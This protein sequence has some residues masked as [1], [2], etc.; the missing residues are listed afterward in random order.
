[1]VVPP[2]Q[3]PE[4]KVQVGSERRAKDDGGPAE[5]VSLARAVGHEDVNG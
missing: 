4:Q 1:M 2:V 5:I 3:E